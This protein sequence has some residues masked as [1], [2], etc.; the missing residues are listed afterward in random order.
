MFFRKEINTILNK[1]NELINIF[2][3]IKYFFSI[4]PFINSF[5]ILKAGFYIIF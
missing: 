3:T 5:K 2:F 1:L 4:I